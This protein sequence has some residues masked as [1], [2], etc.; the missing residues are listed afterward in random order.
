MSLYSFAYRKASRSAFAR[1]VANSNAPVA[2]PADFNPRRH[3]I[4]ARHW[5]GCPTP[6]ESSIGVVNS[7][8]LRLAAA[9]HRLGETIGANTGTRAEMLRRL[10]LRV[11]EAQREV[12]PID[13]GR[14]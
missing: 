6:A 8:L 2:L 7:D 11:H 4:L 14:R 12:V 9:L 1:A 13:G 3:P 10:A 5:F